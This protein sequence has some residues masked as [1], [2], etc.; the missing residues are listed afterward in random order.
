MF[1][2]VVLATD[3]SDA[4]NYTIECVAAWKQLELQ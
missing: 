1:D 4:S 2:R 3:F